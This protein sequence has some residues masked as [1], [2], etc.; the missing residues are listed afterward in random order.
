MFVAFPTIGPVESHP[1]TIAS[2]PEASESGKEGEFELMWIVRV[3]D[4]F[5]RRLK[6]HILMKNH[7]QVELGTEGPLKLQLPIFMD[8][9]YGAPPDI[10]RFETCV[11]FGGEFMALV[12]TCSI[13]VAYYSA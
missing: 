2:I 6:E 4:G 7:R 5:T 12:D 9:P 1:F 8:G 10:S 13:L 11:F 3:R